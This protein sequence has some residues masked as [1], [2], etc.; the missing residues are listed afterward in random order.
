MR[1][2]EHRNHIRWN[3]STRSVITDHR[4]Q[5]EYDFDWNNVKILDEEPCYGK[6]CLISEMIHI[7][8][9]ENNLNLQYRRPS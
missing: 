4:M 3:I 2:K 7:K 9:Q 8:K 1:I 6:R 5:S